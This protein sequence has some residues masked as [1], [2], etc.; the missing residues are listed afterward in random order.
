[1]RRLIPAL[2]AL[3]FAT[4]ARAQSSTASVHPNL[5]VLATA[6]PR[7]GAILIDGKLTEAA[8]AAAQ[9]LTR[10]TQSQPIEGAPAPCH[11]AALNN[12]VCVTRP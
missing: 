10:F 8:W 11:L 1:M 5:P 4:T 9:P 7:T 12:S 6:S 2:A 3:A